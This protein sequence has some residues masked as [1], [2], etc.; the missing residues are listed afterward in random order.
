MKI[1]VRKEMPWQEDASRKVMGLKPGASKEFFPVKRLLKCHSS[2]LYP[3]NII[4]LHLTA[5]IDFQLFNF[6]SLSIFS[7]L[8]RRLI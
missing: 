7:G 4:C 2:G 1:P 5:G 8:M 3:L 6:G